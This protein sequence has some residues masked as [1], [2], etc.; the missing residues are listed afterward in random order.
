MIEEIIN[1]IHK[2]LKNGYP[3]S[4][5]GMALTIPDICG[6]IAY[7]EARCGER[8][9]RWFNEYVSPTNCLQSGKDYRLFDGEICYKLRCAY[10]H[11][12]NFD[13]GHKKAVKDIEQFTL[14]YNQ[15]PELRFMKIAQA[16]DG[17]YQIGIDLG[18]LCDQLCKAAKIFCESH[19]SACAD[20]TV[21]IKNETPSPEKRKEM[22]ERL[23][24]TTG[25]TIEQLKEKIRQDKDFAHNL[26]IDWWSIIF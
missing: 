25:Y 1:E 17:R 22:I 24:K 14:H 15:D 12:G 2:L 6:N 4:A 7:P 21:E 20:M 18:V 11:S 9:I 5:L 26:N 3:Y 8:Y 23:E 16:P 13:L 10:L 19:Q